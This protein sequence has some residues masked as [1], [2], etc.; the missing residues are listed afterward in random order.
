LFSSLYSMLPSAKSYLHQGGL[1]P[2]AA[3]YAIIGCFL[4]GV[5]G[6][7][8]VSRV[9]HHYIPS[10]VVDCGHSPEEPSDGSPGQQG[11]TH[12]SQAKKH[13][14][15]Q[16][17]LLAERAQHVNPERLQRS[18]SASGE[19]AHQGAA[20]DPRPSLP[21]RV[22]K[23]VSGAKSDCRGDGRCFGYSDPCAQ[24]E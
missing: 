21:T 9:M 4:G 11:Y 7:Q 19:F 1:S 10:H 18:V 13:V 23:L 22:S 6:I 16:S 5:I 2:Q 14:D 3:A 20:L 15:E 24:G 8:F 17:P 12:Q